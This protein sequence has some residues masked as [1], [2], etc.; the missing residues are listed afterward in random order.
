MPP[1]RLQLE[2]RDEQAYVEF[3][4]NYI[5]LAL[6]GA[7]FKF[8]TTDSFYDYLNAL[9]GPEVEQYVAELMSAHQSAY[10]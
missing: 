4:D 2:L 8:L 10:A 1:P 9:H 6:D 7:S 3:F 5:V